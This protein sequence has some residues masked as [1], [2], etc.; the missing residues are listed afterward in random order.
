MFLQFLAH[1]QTFDRGVGWKRPAV[2]FSLSFSRETEYLCQNDVGDGTTGAHADVIDQLQDVSGSG[3]LYRQE[4]VV[5]F[6]I[7]RTGMSKGDLP[8]VSFSSFP[9]ARQF[10]TT[11]ER[12]PIKKGQS[13]RRFVA[14]T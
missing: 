8:R 1:A 2:V 7:D 14:G 6:S 5:I 9:G 11:L 12:R 13:A 3:C 4:I 10:L